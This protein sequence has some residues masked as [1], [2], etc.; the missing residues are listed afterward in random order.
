FVSGGFGVRVGGCVLRIIAAVLT[1][2]V[3]IALM[4]GV[5]LGAADPT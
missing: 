4:V 5:L 2:G 1:G 3:A